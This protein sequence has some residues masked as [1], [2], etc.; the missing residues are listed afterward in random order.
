MTDDYWEAEGQALQEWGEQARADER[1]WK[2]AFAAG[3]AKGH[4]IER[5]A[6]V[7]WLRAREKYGYAG[8]PAVAIE[9]GEHLK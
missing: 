3:L 5:A 6:V 2:D 7:K 9:A 4:A 1:L 8:Y